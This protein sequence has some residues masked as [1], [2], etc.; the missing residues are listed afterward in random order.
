MRL[1]VLLCIVG[2][3]VAAFSLYSSWKQESRPGMRHYLKGMEYLNSKNPAAAQNEWLAGMKED[4]A[5]FQCFEQMGDLYTELKMYPEAAYCYGKAVKLVPGDGSLNLRLA[6]SQRSADQNDAAYLSAKRARELLPDD[7]DAQGVYGLLELERHNQALGL[8][9][10]HRALQIRPNDPAY[11]LALARA[12]LQAT[13]VPAA[14]R[15]LAPYL[16]QHPDDADA[17]ELMAE[18]TSRKPRTPKTIQATTRF[19]EHAVAGHTTRE[20]AY[21]LLG[22]LSLD[23]GRTQDALHTFQ[24]GYTR[25]GNSEAIL[26]GLLDCYARLNDAP[27]RDRV[28]EVL[29]QTVARHQRMTHLRDQVSL[30]A[31]ANEAVLELAQLTEQ[32]GDLNRA[33]FFFERLAQR[34]PGNARYQAALE[35]FRSRMKAASEQPAPPPP[36]TGTPHE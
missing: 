6:K 31:D 36:P 35:A 16:Q 26:K 27:H 21:T 13:D 23:S 15:D 8:T 1:L 29:Q 14:E 17:N 19:A 33:Q 32:D 25:F 11:T 24:D 3:T 20:D 12:E 7:A 5:S 4:P 2:G 22:H 30:H 18:I 28:A 10:L 9:A 34:N